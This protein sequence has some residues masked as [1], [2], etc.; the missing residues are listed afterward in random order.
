MTL[1]EEI[2]IGTLVRMR[3]AL[4]ETEDRLARLRDEGRSP[5][6][7]EIRETAA[8]RSAL[9]RDIEEMES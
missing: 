8:W 9:V 7:E 2:R 3:R 5:D 6:D 1:R 4:D